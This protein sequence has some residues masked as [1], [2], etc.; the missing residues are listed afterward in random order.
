MAKKCNEDFESEIQIT[1]NRELLNN[2]LKAPPPYKTRP[3]FSNSVNKNKKTNKYFGKFGNAEESKNSNYKTLSQRPTLTPKIKTRYYS[4]LKR[5]DTNI[6]LLNGQYKNLLKDNYNANSN[7]IYLER[8]KLVIKAIENKGEMKNKIK[9]YKKNKEKEQNK[10]KEKNMKMKEEYGKNKKMK[11]N[12]KK[13]DVR[14]MKEKEKKMLALY[15]DNLKEIRKKK[16]KIKEE[17]KQYIKEKLSQQKDRYKKDIEIRRRINRE[18]EIKNAER[19]DGYR[20]YV[21]RQMENELLHK[22][23]IERLLYKE[24]SNIWFNNKR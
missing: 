12:I 1:F 5:L 9:Q 8:R 20:V 11:L 15:E 10:E 23:K 21:K 14:D 7:N 13:K 6:S 16:L 4:I 19:L 18:K 17:E 22:L 3:N 24:L 2:Y